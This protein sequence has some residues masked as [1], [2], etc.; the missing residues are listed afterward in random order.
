MHEIAPGILGIHQFNLLHGILTKKVRLS[1]ETLSKFFKTFCWQNMPELNYCDLCL[2]ELLPIVSLL[3][4]PHKIFL[5]RKVFDSNAI[6]CNPARYGY[7][8]FIFLNRDSLSIIST[9]LSSL[10]VLMFM[11]YLASNNVTLQL[12]SSSFCV[13]DVA[14]AF[15]NFDSQQKNRWL[16]W[17]IN[18]DDINILPAPVFRKEWE[19][20]PCL[21]PY[22]W[23]DC[24]LVMFVWINTLAN[25]HF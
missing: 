13:G 25:S 18:V 24:F 15:N 17:Q 11:V 20:L 8:T 16:L 10:F 6:N 2:F 7:F 12:K 9:F 3:Q 21:S 4:L 14:I 19:C 1:F 22:I 5:K 23:M